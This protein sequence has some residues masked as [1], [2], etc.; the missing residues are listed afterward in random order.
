VVVHDGGNRLDDEEGSD[1]RDEDD[2]EEARAA[3]EAT[4][5]HVAP[6][7]RRCAVTGGGAFAE[8]LPGGVTVVGAGCVGHRDAGD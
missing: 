3:R 1:E 2:D 4:E 6:A 5:D 7:A 8:A